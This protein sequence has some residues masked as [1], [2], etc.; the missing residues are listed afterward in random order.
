MTPAV[1]V[2]V[3]F[4]S[5]DDL[6]HRIGELYAT[7]VVR[8]M[9]GNDIP[10]SHYAGGQE[11][12][13]VSSW[14][15]RGKTYVNYEFSDLRIDKAG[16]FRLRVRIQLFDFHGVEELCHEDSSVFMVE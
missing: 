4:R 14:T 15:A 5:D 16:T 2:R 3:Q 13:H 12:Q 7:A 10:Y 6:R 8:D 1:K 9:N 11:N